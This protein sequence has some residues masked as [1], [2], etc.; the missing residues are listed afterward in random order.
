MAISGILPSQENRLADT[1]SA[2]LTSMW[3]D[4]LLQEMVCLSRLYTQ[5]PNAKIT[6][7]PGM[8]YRAFGDFSNSHGQYSS[9]RGIHRKL[10]TIMMSLSSRSTVT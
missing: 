10:S 9:K 8:R 6:A 7:L 1:H 4:T 2:D 3:P 5:N